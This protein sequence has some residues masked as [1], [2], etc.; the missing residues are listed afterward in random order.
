M[1][2]SNCNAELSTTAEWCSQCLT[3]VKASG[4]H[5]PS[6]RSEPEPLVMKPPEYSAVRK[7]PYSFG[8]VGK[9]VITAVVV[10]IGLGL[11]VLSIW[12]TNYLETP[13]LA[14]VW[15]ILIPYTVLGLLVLWGTWRPT[16]VK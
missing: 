16:R 8:I 4:Q 11:L 10:L 15:L 3:P 12:M 2:C 6:D 13:G 1:R 7:G 14:L 5:E 9:L